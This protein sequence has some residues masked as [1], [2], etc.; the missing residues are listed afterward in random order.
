[1]SHT[2]DVRRSKSPNP[3]AH[4]CP[5]SRVSRGPHGHAT[6]GPFD[7]LCDA[8]FWGMEHFMDDLRR[9]IHFA[10]DIFHV[11]FT[12]TSVA[13]VLKRAREA[14]RRTCLLAR[15]VFDDYQSVLLRPR[16][17]TSIDWESVDSQLEKAPCGIRGSSVFGGALSL[18]TG[19]SSSLF[20]SPRVWV[21]RVS[22]WVCRPTVARLMKRSNDFA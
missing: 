11:V 2:I 7:T 5:V 18:L 19:W 17:S 22:C 15:Q 16:F 9:R 8:Y 10:V 13:H 20:S 6:L 4:S 1:M 21:A 3:P 12:V 14:I